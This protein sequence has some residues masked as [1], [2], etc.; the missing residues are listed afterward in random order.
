[1]WNVI[2]YRKTN[3]KPQMKK[4]ETNVFFHLTIN[5]SAFIHLIVTINY[6]DVTD[7]Q[8][9][10]SN[11]RSDQ[12]IHKAPQKLFLLTDAL[13]SVMSGRHYS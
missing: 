8:A 11:I 12:I 6:S 3:T 13:G 9:L 5:G 1:M 2:K 4:R 7:S 10:N